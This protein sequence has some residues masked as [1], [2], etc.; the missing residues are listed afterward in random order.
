MNIRHA[1]F[2][3]IPQKHPLYMSGVGEDAFAPTI[4][5]RLE[6]DFSE[7]QKRKGMLGDQQ[8]TTRTLITT[9]DLDN[10]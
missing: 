7:I 3:P 9:I 2:L 4:H 8:N 6:V 5:M 1:G 10:Y